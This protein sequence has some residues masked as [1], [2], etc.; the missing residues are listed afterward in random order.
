[1]IRVALEISSNNQHGHGKQQGLVRY[2]V[3]VGAVSAWAMFLRELSGSE[4]IVLLLSRPSGLAWI[5]FLRSAVC[6]GSQ[7]VSSS[8]ERPVMMAYE[9]SAGS[10]NSELTW[11]LV[12]RK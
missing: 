3:A 6:T 8:P 4:G 7:A 10:A 9:D 12:Q 2:H 1:M 5:F 11:N